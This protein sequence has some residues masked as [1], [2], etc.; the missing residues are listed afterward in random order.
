[1]IETLQDAAAWGI[2]VAVG[3]LFFYS[4]D[5]GLRRG[6]FAALMTGSIIILGA[7]GWAVYWALDQLWPV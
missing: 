1:M 2:L 5:R 4:M 6:S 3:M 7:I